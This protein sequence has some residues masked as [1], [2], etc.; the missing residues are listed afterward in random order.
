MAAL[1]E[2]TERTRARAALVA[3]QHEEHTRELQQWAVAEEDRL[4]HKKA[5]V[6]AS[7]AR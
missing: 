2:E 7:E 4:A 3:A 5:Q 6:D 1:H